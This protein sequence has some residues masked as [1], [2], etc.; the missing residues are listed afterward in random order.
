MSLFAPTKAA[1]G[2]AGYAGT[3]LAANVA[4]LTL[5]PLTV[6]PGVLA[7]AGVLFAGLAFTARDLVQKHGGRAAAVLAVGI[8]IALAAGFAWTTGSPM[9]I[10]LASAIA[11]AVSETLDWGVF[12]VFRRRFLLAVALSGLAGLIV[13][14]LIFLPIAFGGLAFLSGQLIGK[15]YALIAALAVLAV[16]RKYRTARSVQ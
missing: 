5:P 8:G 16:A 1:L 6:W 13:D 9:R 10:I 11:F 2:I 3:V 14:S 4:L 15:T 12:E 7:P